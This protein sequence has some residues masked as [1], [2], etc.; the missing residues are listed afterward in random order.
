MGTL[1]YVFFGYRTA[2]ATNRNGGNAVPSS[3]IN[4]PSTEMCFP[5]AA[6]TSQMM[7]STSQVMMSI[8]QNLGSKLLDLGRSLPY[9]GKILPYLG[10]VCLA[11]DLHCSTREGNALATGYQIAVTGGYIWLTVAQK[12]SA[13][14]KNSHS[15]GCMRVVVA[16][17]RVA[18]DRAKRCLLESCRFGVG[19]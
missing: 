17:N 1:R 14:A 13:D 12:F 11:W 16:K 10:R 18:F 8:S 6:N 19:M 9:L 4:F 2:R 3:V 15:F 5:V 7:T